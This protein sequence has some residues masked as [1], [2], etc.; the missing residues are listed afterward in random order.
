VQHLRDGALRTAFLNPLLQNHRHVQAVRG[1]AGAGVP[2]AGLVVSAGAGRFCGEL[3]P[4][5]VSVADLAGRLG[6]LHTITEGC[7][8]ARLDAIWTRLMAAAA[9]GVWRGDARRA[10]RAGAAPAR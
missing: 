5:V 9:C 3:E 1:L 6:A 8:P 2:V 4:A 10:P 7:D